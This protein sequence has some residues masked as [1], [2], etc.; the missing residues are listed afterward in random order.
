[1]KQLGSSNSRLGSDASRA[2]YAGGVAILSAALA[3]VAAQAVGTAALANTNPPVLTTEELEAIDFSVSVLEQ[4]DQ[5]ILD[6]RQAIAEGAPIDSGFARVV[7]DIDAVYQSAL[8]RVTGIKEFGFPLNFAIV[9]G[10]ALD[11]NTNPSALS[12]ANLAEGDLLIG[13]TLAGEPLE[14][15]ILGMDV[16]WTA[17]E[18]FVLD[19]EYANLD[20]DPETIALMEQIIPRIAVIEAD[21]IGPDGLALAQGLVVIERL[22]EPHRPFDIIAMPIGALPESGEEEQVVE[23]QQGP[24]IVPGAPPQKPKRRFRHKGACIVGIVGTTLGGSTCFSTLLG[25]PASIGASCKAA[26]FSCCATLEWT[27][28]VTCNACNWMDDHWCTA[29]GVGGAI[30]CGAPLYFSSASQGE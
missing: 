9:T 18:T 12:Q 22:S 3:F 11:L 2:G 24:I 14:L 26:F 19:E 5:L 8:G 27:A 23:G 6:T 20:L 1:M 21:V 13:T 17:L 15:A 16:G 30:S 4:V 28:F 25:C 10:Q 7:S 29:I